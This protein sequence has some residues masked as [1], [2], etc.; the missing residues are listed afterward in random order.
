M[1]D[2]WPSDAESGDQVRRRPKPY[3]FELWSYRMAATF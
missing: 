3:W 1:S 2:L